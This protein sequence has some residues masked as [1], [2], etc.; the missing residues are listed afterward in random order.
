MFLYSSIAS[1]TSCQAHHHLASLCLILSSPGIR[2]QQGLITEA[3]I[4]GVFKYFF[5]EKV[6]L[7]YPE[8]KGQISTRFRGEHALRRYKNGEERC[9]ACKLDCKDSSA[10]FILPQ[11]VIDHPKIAAINLHPS[12]LPRWRG[13]AP[14]Q[15]AFLNCDI[16]NCKI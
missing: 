2:S 11:A 14:M 4:M 13:A 7:N 10:N 12:L 16:T 9:I 3:S 6:T 5:A 1:L 15:Q 8:E